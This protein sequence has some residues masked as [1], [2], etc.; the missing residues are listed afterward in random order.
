MRRLVELGVVAATGEVFTA[1]LDLVLSSNLLV[2][3]NSGGGKSWLLRRMIEQ[4]FGR[5]PQLIVDSEGE[6]STLRSKFNV[7][8]VG[9]E[10]DT[11]ADVQRP[12]G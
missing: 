2:Q 9:R 5:V 12:D 6:F 10:G 7:V 1:D 4:V 8:L 3:A 11:P